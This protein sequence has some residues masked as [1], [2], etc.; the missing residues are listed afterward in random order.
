[1]ADLKAIGVFETKGLT[2]LI[3]GTDAAVK[4]A[5]VDIIEWRP[6]GSGFVSCLFEGEV[7]SVR[8]AMDAARNSAS[9]IG[10]VTAVYVIPRPVDEI[11]TSIGK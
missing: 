9:Q 6:V 3:V 5:N 11:R 1:M 7:A 2:P 4:A 8:S 10:E